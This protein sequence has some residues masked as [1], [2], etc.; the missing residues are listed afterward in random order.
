MQKISITLCVLTCIMIIFSFSLNERANNVQDVEELG[1]CLIKAKSEWGKKCLNC[2]VFT[3]NNKISYDDTY[4]V[5][6]TNSCD[7]SIDAK[8]CV[9]EKDGSWKCY[10]YNE[11]TSK[12]TIKAWACMGTGKYLKWVKKAGDGQL[13][14]PTDQEVHE[15]YPPEEEE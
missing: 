13:V 7:Y 4:Q 10:K 5:Y 11:M 15:Q 1:N 9:Q 14:F 12:D 3:G 2:G 6:L 8:C